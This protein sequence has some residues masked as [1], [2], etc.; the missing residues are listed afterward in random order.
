MTQEPTGP[1]RALFRSREVAE[2]LGLSEAKV[3]DLLAR[4]ELRAVKV[5][6][7]L[8]FAQV[9]IQNYVDRLRREA[10]ERA[11]ADGI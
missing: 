5:G 7:A 4:R 6:R 8:R 2:L 11:K 10:E 9:D 1:G 3:F